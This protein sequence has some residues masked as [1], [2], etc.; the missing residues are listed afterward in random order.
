MRKCRQLINNRHPRRGGIKNV[1]MLCSFSLNFQL[2]Q[3]TVIEILLNANPNS[4]VFVLKY[5]VAIESV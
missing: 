1:L 3:I 4:L 2:D 5:S